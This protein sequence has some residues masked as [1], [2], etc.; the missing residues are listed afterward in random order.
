MTSLL[1]LIHK[2]IV[3]TTIAWRFTA[4]A[5]VAGSEATD[6]GNRWDAFPLSLKLGSNA[7]DAKEITMLAD[8]MVVTTVA[9]TDLD[10]AKR[11]FAEQLGLP[12]LDEMPFAIR[13]GSGKGTQISVRRGQPNVGQTVAHFEVDDIESVIRE[14][15]SHGVRFEEYE[16]PKTTNFIAQVGPARAAWFTDPDGNIFG[17]REGPVPGV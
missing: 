3:D 5:A 2:P 12:M 8:A 4:S 11:F 6:N 7:V 15:S 13:F 16:A 1:Q 10:R 14:L 9:T 17:L